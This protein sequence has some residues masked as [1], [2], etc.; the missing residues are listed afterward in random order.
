MLVAAVLAAMTSGEKNGIR[1]VLDGNTGTR[2]RLK[3]SYNTSDSGTGWELHWLPVRHMGG[4]LIPD[5]VY[6]SVPYI[7]VCK[8]NAGQQEVNTSVRQCPG[9]LIQLIR[10]PA[11][12][13]VRG[14]AGVRS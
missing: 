9:L 2:G 14:V 4:H 13:T 12:D 10:R 5:T 3:V 7:S 8:W 6:S 11:R 1:V